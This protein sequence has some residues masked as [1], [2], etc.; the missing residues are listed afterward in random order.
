MSVA[1][2]GSLIVIEGLDGGGKKT[3]ST[4]LLTRL[5]D[6]GYPTDLLSFPL[7]ETPA[8]KLIAAYLHGDIGNKEDIPAELPALFYA[9]DRYQVKWTIEKMINEG[10]NLVVDRYTASN[11]AF[12]TA[13]LPDDEKKSFQNWIEGVE[14]RLPQPDIVLYLHVPLETTRQWIQERDQRA[15]ELSDLK[16]IYERDFAFQ[17]KVQERYLALATEKNWTIIEYADPD[18]T[19]R[20]RRDIHEDI[21][22]AV[23][24]ILNPKS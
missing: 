15:F 11:L 22:E 18:G 8:G 19:I 13:K 6:E 1:N 12:Q 5:K 17:Q 4:L 2:K 14:G 16:D 24:Q 7:Y 20:S 21:W 23:Q 9:L 3:Q 10:I